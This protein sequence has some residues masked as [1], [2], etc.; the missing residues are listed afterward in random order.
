MLEGWLYCEICLAFGRYHLLSGLFM[1]SCFTTWLTVALFGQWISCIPFY[2]KGLATAKNQN[3]LSAE[4]EK[5]EIKKRLCFANGALFILLR[6]CLLQRCLKVSTNLQGLF[7]FSSRE[8]HLRIPSI[9]PISRVSTTIY[10]AKSVC[11]VNCTNNP[12][13]PMSILMYTSGKV[14][15]LMVH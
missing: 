10:K 9:N 13:V 5:Q 14:E 12:T 7:S 2:Y 1:F 4:G 6:V 3:K 11:R 8:F 15:K